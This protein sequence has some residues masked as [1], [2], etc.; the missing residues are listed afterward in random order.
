MEHC[1]SQNTFSET[2]SAY[3][4]HRRTTD[5][6]IKLTQHVSEAFQWS[7]MV[8]FACLDEKAFDAVWRLGLVQKLNLIGLNNSII[9]WINSFYRKGTFL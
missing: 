5:I 8:G 2:Q 7:E 3:R 1:E 9:R 4:K 6:L